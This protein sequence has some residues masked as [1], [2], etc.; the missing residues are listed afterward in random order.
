MRSTPTVDFESRFR[1]VVAVLVRYIA[2]VDVTVT[3]VNIVD[4]NGIIR[5]YVNFA[6]NLK[7]RKAK[8]FDISHDEGG[9]APTGLIS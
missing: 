6:L 2:V 5:K 1:S 9:A 3:F 7:F 4:A 8:V